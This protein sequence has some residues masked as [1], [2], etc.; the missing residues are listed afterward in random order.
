MTINQTKLSIGFSKRSWNK[1]TNK[2]KLATFNQKWLPQML[3]SMM[4]MSIKKLRYQ[5]SFSQDI[6][7]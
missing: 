6:E 4:A 3:P 2:T 7:D 5:F 1:I